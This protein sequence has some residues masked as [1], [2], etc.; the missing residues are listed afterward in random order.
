MLLITWAEKLLERGDKID[1]LVEQ[2]ENLENQSFYFKKQSKKLYWAV[3]VKNIKLLI[4]ISI[5]LIVNFFFVLLVLFRTNNSIL[6]ICIWL[7]TSLMCGFNYACLSF[8]F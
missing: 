1:L 4:L 8:I 6:Q 3:I 2:S 5:I 7:A